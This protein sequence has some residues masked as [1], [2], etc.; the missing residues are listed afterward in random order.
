M[1]YKVLPTFFQGMK[2]MFEGSHYTE[3][4]CNALVYSKLSSKMVRQFRN[5][6]PDIH[7]VVTQ[8]EKLIS[9]HTYAL[10]RACTIHVS[11]VADMRVDWPQAAGTRKR[12][13]RKRR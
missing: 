9:P 2:K 4:D 12:K 6:V 7:D 11:D 8:L 1:D 13:S 10:P 3:S 5:G